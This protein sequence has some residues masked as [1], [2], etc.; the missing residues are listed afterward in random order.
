MKRTSIKKL[1]LCIIIVLLASKKQK[2]NLV[3]NIAV[4]YNI[5]LIQMMICFFND[6][7]LLNKNY[8]YN[9]THNN[10]NNK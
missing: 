7:H 8:L 2:V 10:E 3:N 9:S 4:G 6:M 5:L 1:Y